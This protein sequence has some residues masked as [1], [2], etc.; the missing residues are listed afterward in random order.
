MATKA[1]NKAGPAGEVEAERAMWVD[2]VPAP[3]DAQ[4]TMRQTTASVNP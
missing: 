3:R 2:R 1:T 4:H